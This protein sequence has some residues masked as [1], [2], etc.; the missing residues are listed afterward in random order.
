MEY[1][2]YVNIFETKGLEY[3]LVICF[4]VTFVF[5]V[6]RLDLPARRAPVPPP[7]PVGITDG[8]RAPVHPDPHP[9]GSTGT[10]AGEAGPDRG[11]PTG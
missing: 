7:G 2:H 8:G 6:R 11:A 1:Y 3:I 5:F 4:L 9:R 10:P